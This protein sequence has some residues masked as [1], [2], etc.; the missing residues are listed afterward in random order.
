MNSIIQKF[1]SELQISISSH[2]IFLHIQNS[3]TISNE[4]SRHDTETQHLRYK[5]T[6]VYMFIRLIEIN[7]IK[8]RNNEKNT[9]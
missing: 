3:H 1:K 7:M 5:N 9:I 2:H 6:H 8:T 4:L